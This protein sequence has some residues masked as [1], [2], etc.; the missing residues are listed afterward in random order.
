MPVAHFV[1]FG[2]DRTTLVLFLTVRFG[3]VDSFDVGYGKSMVGEKQVRVII[4]ML[5]DGIRKWHNIMF[6]CFKVA[7]FDDVRIPIQ[8]LKLLV[9]VL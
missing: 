4:N 2:F 5:H 9:G 7:H 3:G 8:Q 1:G 6:V